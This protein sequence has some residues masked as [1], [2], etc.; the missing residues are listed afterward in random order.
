VPS[1]QASAAEV[2]AT[3]DRPL[4]LDPGLGLG[5]FV[6]DVPFQCAIRVRLTPV[7]LK[8]DPTAQAL[9]V[10]VAATPDR[11]LPLDPGLGLGTF[12]QD[13]PFQCAIRVRLTPVPL[14]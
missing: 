11:P 1:A 5:T 14:K 2:A 6:Q 12:V 10:E 8:Y 4:P 9:A 3:A 7:P 13:V